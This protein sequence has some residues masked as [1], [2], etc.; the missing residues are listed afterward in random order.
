MNAVDVGQ[1]LVLPL[2]T[3]QISRGAAVTGWIGR[4]I[5]RSPGCRKAFVRTHASRMPA[6]TDEEVADSRF[7]R[8]PAT[9]KFFD[10]RR[11]ITPRPSQ[12]AALRSRRRR[13]QRGGA[14]RW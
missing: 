3:A 12:S 11:R 13:A 10:G 5:E 4:D 9:V 14:L 2:T 7:G 8:R 6:L 1:A